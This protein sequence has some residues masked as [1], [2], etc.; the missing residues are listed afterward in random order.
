MGGA[1]E[2]MGETRNANLKER[3]RW[4]YIGVYTRIV[5][6]CALKELGVVSYY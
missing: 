5:L 1:A 4:R 3:H 2:H 6:K